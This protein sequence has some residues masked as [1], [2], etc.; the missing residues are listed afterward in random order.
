[1]LGIVGRNGVGKTTTLKAI[2]GLVDVYT[3]TIA[4]TGRARFRPPLEGPRRTAC[5]V[6]VGLR[7]DLAAFNGD[8]EPDVDDAGGAVRRGVRREDRVRRQHQRRLHVARR[9][10]RTDPESAPTSPR[11][12]GQNR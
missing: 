11:T 1:M 8:S 2:M 9:T 7:I 6:E 10:V 4:I 5:P 12:R 3:G